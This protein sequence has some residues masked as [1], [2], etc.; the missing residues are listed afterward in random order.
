M[1]RIKRLP[2]RHAS[3]PEGRDKID[4]GLFQAG[5]GVPG[6]HLGAFQGRGNDS[7]H[8]QFGDMGTEKIIETLARSIISSFF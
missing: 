5:D 7:V 3:P 4:G 2:T 8:L 1:A 6:A